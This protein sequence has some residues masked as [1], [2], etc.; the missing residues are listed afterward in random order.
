MAESKKITKDQV[1]E[2]NLY[3]EFIE[4]TETALDRV[5]ALDLG[6]KGML[7]TQRS[8]IEQGRN[9]LQNPETIRKVNEAMRDSKVTREAINQVEKQSIAL[10][11]KLKTL[12]SD[13]IQS[14]EELKILIS[15]QAKI[16]KELA[17]EKL[18]L[19]TLYDK[20]SKRLNELRKKYKDVALEKGRNS[21]EAKKLRKETIDLDKSLK[22]LDADVG[23]HNRNI[24]NYT[25][26]LTALPGR[27]GQVAGSVKELGAQF[28]RLL[29]NPIVAF[30]AAITLAVTALF[31]GFASTDKG[32]V[33]LAGAME[34]LSAVTSVLLQRLGLLAEA[35]VAFF[36]GDF[37]GAKNKAA[38]AFANVADQINAAIEAGQ[39]YREELDNIEDAE[40]AFAETRARNRKKIAELEFA[41]A[42]RSRSIS[43]RRKDLEEAIAL[44]EE[45][46]KIEERFA[47]ERFEAQLKNQAARIGVSEKQLK[48]FIEL[49]GDAAEQAAKID[50]SARKIRE[51]NAG[52]SEKLLED[53]AAKVQDAQTKFF[54]EQKRNNAKVSGLR[55]E[56]FQLLVEEQ[57]RKNSLI[58]A[59]T[60]RELAEEDLRH[61]QAV[62]KAKKNNEN[63]ETIEKQH[64]D[65][66]AK[67]QQDA[68]NR[69]QEKANKKQDEEVERIQ[70]DHEKALKDAE[71]F[72]ET[73]NKRR[74]VATKE[75]SKERLEAEID[76]IE[77]ERDV[78][79]LN[80]HL[81]AD[82]RFLIEQEALEKIEALR[83]EFRNKEIKEQV[84]QLEAI[85]D[86]FDKELSK[87]RDKEK[88]ALDDEIKDRD[89]N[90][91]RQMELAEKGADNILAFE[92]QKEQEAELRKKQLEEQEAKRKEALLLAEAYL[93]A[94]ISELEQP[95]SNPTTAAVKALADVVLAKAIGA[96][97]AGA[98]KDGT[99]KLEGPGT[100]TSDSLLIRA[101]KGEGV[102]KATGVA[103][104]PGLVTAMNEG[105]VKDYTEDV[106]IPKFNLDNQAS[107]KVTIQKASESEIVGKKLLHEISMVRQEL[108][109][110]P[111]PSFRFDEQGNLWENIWRNGNVSKIKHLPPKL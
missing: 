14:N 43:A 111:V 103:S 93:Q 47:R 36:S 58:K 16:N 97:L 15:Q 89:E 19:V 42:D 41:A 3:T 95:G 85:A 23:Q 61:L 22:Q 11:E 101:S 4:D 70:K 72:R 54:E 64:Q 110:R 51:F 109:K 28:L 78:L 77:F 91:K 60:E 21:S 73:E 37:S 83:R 2:K 99:E 105:S 46:A 25:D 8:V 80:A 45:E 68:F 12:R 1:F 56:E 48:R 66:I 87:R 40:T 94:F 62:R 79:L 31:K 32:A 39:Q 81:T 20:E 76:A 102:V 27:L 52:E 6:L 44:S 108:A 71:T 18:G 50:E 10:E 57:A 75:G 38:A 35:A 84:D 65:N 13:E 92:I 26:S 33:K 24:G 55:E 9:G 53:L 98:F 88:K 7:K 5:K 17:K 63:L 107:A 104:H 82:E 100:T 30:I 67:I 96:T 49:D 86:A 74:I 34:A 90:I 69:A 59:Q 29:A 106:L